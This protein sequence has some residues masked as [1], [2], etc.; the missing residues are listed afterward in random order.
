MGAR[1]TVPALS[2]LKEPHADPVGDY[3]CKVDPARARGGPLYCTASV[4]LKEPRADPVG[5]YYARRTTR[6]GR[7]GTLQGRRPGL[8]VWGARY[9]VPPLS[10]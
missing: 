3:Q 8:G 2:L 4:P 5:D 6:P 10:L 1:Y 7:G 9:T